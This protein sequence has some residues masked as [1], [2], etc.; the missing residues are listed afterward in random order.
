MGKSYPTPNVTDPVLSVNY[1]DIA[2]KLIKQRLL[3]LE[4][5]NDFT[6]HSTLVHF[7]STFYQ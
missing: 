3:E 4:V 6:I 7:N 5:Y 2:V 1:E